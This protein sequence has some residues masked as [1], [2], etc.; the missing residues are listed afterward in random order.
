MIHINHPGQRPLV[1]PTSGTSPITLT[2]HIPPLVLIS[3]KPI[4]IARSP[5]TRLWASALICFYYVLSWLPSSSFFS[6]TLP[7]QLR[8]KT[9]KNTNP[10]YPTLF[11][12]ITGPEFAHYSPSSSGHLS[13]PLLLSSIEL[14]TLESVFSTPPLSTPIRLGRLSIV[15]IDVHC[16]YWM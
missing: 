2:G 8:V 10:A 1:D 16:D 5:F 6:G 14:K 12:Y 3:L 11:P 4:E 7:S 15:S 13:S 9:R